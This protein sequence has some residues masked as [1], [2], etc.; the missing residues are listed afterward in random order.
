MKQAGT[1]AACVLLTIAASAGTPTASAQVDQERAERAAET[2]Q[3]LLRV[4]VWNFGPLAA[5]A[6]D[7]IEFDAERVAINAERLAALSK[8]LSDA[9]AADTRGYDLTTEALDVIW[10][11]PD[12]FAEKI[13]ANMEA[14]EALA[15]AAA[16][17][18]EGAMTRAIGEL[19][20]T[21]GSCHDDFRVDD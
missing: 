14:S 7:R 6:R 19:G 11:R 2:R 8:M 5:M 9:F 16:T 21:C 3:A 18:D 17:G 20:S 13:R 4:M 1:L 10:E 15:A 12:A